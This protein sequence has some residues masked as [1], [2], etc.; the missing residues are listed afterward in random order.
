VGDVFMLIGAHPM[1]HA[2]QFVVVRRAAG[3]PVVI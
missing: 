1:M 3:K 2:G